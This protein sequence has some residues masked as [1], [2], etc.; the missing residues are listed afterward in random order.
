MKLENI[1]IL[2][3][4][5]TL[6]VWLFIGIENPLLELN[7]PIFAIC[8]NMFVVFYIIGYLKY[9]K[10]QKYIC[11]KRKIMIRYLEEYVKEK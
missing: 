5:I 7:R 9:E 1:F 10:E 11:A 2:L 8:M 4:F 3:S 6:I